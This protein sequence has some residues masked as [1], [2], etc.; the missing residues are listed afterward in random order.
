MRETLNRLISA[1]RSRGL[2]LLRGVP[3]EQHAQL[4]GSLSVCR[5]RLG[6]AQDALR[7]LERV[8]GTEIGKRVV[9]HIGFDMSKAVRK[10]IMEAVFKA[11]EAEGVSS[12]PDLIE[13][14][15]FSRDVSWLDPDSLERRV[16]EEWKYQ[17]A[18][19]LQAFVD[20]TN[21]IALERHVTVL[22]VRV[23]QLGYRHHIARFD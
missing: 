9:E 5:A 22:D 16:L 13:L 14:Q 11:R 6:A 2:A 21:P 8:I 10:S 12:M 7:D 23:P 1:L 18:P 20:I 3:Q 19:K 4:E 15:L 17:A